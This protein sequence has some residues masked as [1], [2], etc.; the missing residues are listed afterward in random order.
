M[1]MII[2]NVTI[3]IDKNLE[4]QWRSWMQEKHIKE[5]LATGKFIKAKF[6]KVLVEEQADTTTYCVQYFTKNKQQLD[7]YYLENAPNLREE[8]IKLFGDKML[9]FRT[10]LE[11]LEEIYPL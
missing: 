6:I 9:A 5:V 10:E 7:S 8:S 1:K 11:I 4:S 3:N 2:Y